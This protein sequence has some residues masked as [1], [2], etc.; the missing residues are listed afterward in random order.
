[1][2]QQQTLILIL[3]TLIVGIAIVVAI[4]T[5]HEAS[6][7]S[8]IDAIRQDI[9]S[10]QAYANG[11]AL[12]PVSLGGGGG[13]YYGISLAHLLLDDEN[14]NANYSL[15][16]VMY[17]SFQIIAESSRGFTVVATISGDDVEWERE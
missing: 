7:E 5:F 2:G 3:I 9:F 4:N 1:M 10:A 6:S 17:D 8:N 11:Y 15:G 14:E 16:D 13:S 12:K